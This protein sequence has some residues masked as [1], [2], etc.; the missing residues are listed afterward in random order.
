[1]KLK[2]RRAWL[3][4]LWIV[5]IT[6]ALA[7][8]GGVPQPNNTPTQGSGSTGQ[9]VPPDPP[10]S[11]A[12]YLTALDGIE[13]FAINPTD[14]SLKPLPGS[15]FASSTHTSVLAASPSGSLALGIAFSP[16]NTIWVL[17]IDSQGA[18]QAD[19]SPALQFPSSFGLETLFPNVA[20]SASGKMI[21]LANYI[22][23][24]ILSAHGFDAKAGTIT[25]T[26]SSQ[27]QFPYTPCADPPFCDMTFLSVAGSSHGAA[28]EHVWVQFADFGFH[29]NGSEQL[30]P[31]PISADGTIGPNPDGITTAALFPSVSTWSI[32]SDGVVTVEQVPCCGVVNL[33]SYVFN[34][35]RLVAM[36]GCVFFETGCP[37]A[38]SIVLHPNQKLAII[39]GVDGHLFTAT[40]DEAGN[41]SLPVPMNI[42]IGVSADQLVLDQDGKY[43]YVMPGLSNQI[44]GFSVDANSGVLQAIPG[45][46]WSVPGTGTRSFFTM[47]LPATH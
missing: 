30:E 9:V 32:F 18:M 21:Y 16:G 41:L 37:S 39:G 25:P 3:V 12:L 2:N 11:Q 22:G 14:G 1:M 4:L 7:G 34:N 47:R 5:P 19:T 31:M 43:L 33:G 26:A 38:A 29:L 24:L 42:S 10:P 15:P 40:R 8:C 28:G 23:P 27:V 13:G 46:P 17:R 35:G 44:F 36:Q 45:S 6:V 20:F